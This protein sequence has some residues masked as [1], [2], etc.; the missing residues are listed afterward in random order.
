MPSTESVHFSTHSEL[1]NIIGKDLINDDNIAIVEL[2]KNSVDAGAS[3]IRIVFCQN[4]IIIWDN[5]SGMSRQDIKNKWL[6]IAYSEK[7]NTSNSAHLFA[8]NK[9]V[10]RFA[11]DRLGQ[12][13]DL[14]SVTKV[15]SPLQ[16]SVDWSL[17]EN[18]LRA[19]E[20]IQTIDVKLKAIDKARVASIL[21][22]DFPASGTALVIT[23][24]RQYWDREKLISLRRSLERFM[25]PIAVF[26]SGG[27]TLSIKAQ[28][29]LARDLTE[30]FHNQVNGKIENQ[31]FTQLKFKTTFIESEIS[32][33]GLLLTTRLVH[34][35][36]QVYRLVEKNTVFPLLSGMRTT[37]HYM[38]PYKKAYFKR[39]TGLHLVDFGSIFLFING[40]RVPPYGDRDD[41]WLQ[42]NVRKAQGMARFLG[43]R[44]LLGII[45]VSDPSKLFQIVSNREGVVKDDRFRQLIRSSDGYFISILARLERFVVN[46]LDWDSVTPEIG[47]K[48]K[49]GIVPGDDDMPGGEVYRESTTLKSRRIAVDVLRIVGASAEKTLELDIS[50]DV[51]NSL[52]RERAGAVTAL[53][54]KFGSFDNVLGHDLKLALTK[55]KDEFSKQQ[56]SLLKVKRE[57]S[58]KESQVQ[59][60]KNVARGLDKERVNLNHQLKTQESEIHFSRLSASTDQEQ[61]LLLH[62]QSGLY[63]QTA[64]NYI[65]HLIVQLR[66]GIDIE[67][68][69][70]TAEKALLSTKKIIAV[71]NFATKANFRLQ[72]ELI[73][74]DIAS[75]IR[76]YLENVAR[77]SSAQNLRLTVTQDFAEPFVMRFKPIDVAIIFDNLAS[78]STRATAR[79]WDIVLSRPSENELIIRA[80]DD[81]PG[82]RKDVFLAKAYLSAV[83]RRQVDPDLAY[84]TYV[85]P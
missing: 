5:G 72:S 42:L 75:F 44:E 8:G 20:A 58:R 18:K 35:G 10:G 29:E 19:S 15:S 25:N 77:D 6:N 85:K 43:T 39:Q 1:K 31:I 7:R 27:L 22:M 83:S 41:D 61:L 36:E 49:A 48:L 68:V 74:A 84:I 30:K 63:A 21:D 71:S 70:I 54:D 16:V 26:E 60:L 3:D 4:R 11:C 46:G 34:E 62:H 73:T 32:V 81:G 45:D 50:T 40:F 47:K 66:K 64:K 2:V 59:R 53:L 23:E 52:S 79:K 24:L 80:Q 67:K 78:N 69:V 37:I 82:L 65:D 28:H 14:F 17:F 12:K 76:E 38:N 56:D 13:L 57:I 33:D 55:L 51:L 9:G